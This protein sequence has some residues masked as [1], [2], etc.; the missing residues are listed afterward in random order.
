MSFSPEASGMTHYSELN[1]H[2]F[3]S[4]DCRMPYLESVIF[5]ALI[6]YV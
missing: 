5:V 4:T 1:T 3:A 6:A 2:N